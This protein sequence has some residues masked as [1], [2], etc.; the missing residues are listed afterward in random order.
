MGDAAA[1]GYASGRTGEPVYDEIVTGT[2]SLRAHWQPLLAQ[3]SPLNSKDMA[4]RVE[5]SMRLL[6]ENDVTYTVYGDPQNIAQ[7]NERLWPLDIMP[8][9]ISAEE[10]R[11]I[12][13]G[14]LQRARLLNT[15]LG[16]IY[17]ARRCVADGVLP[18]M[19]LEGNPA[20][21]RPCHD[22][23]PIGGTYLHLYAADLGR[24]ANGQWCVLA[25]RTETPSG[26]GYALENRS[27]IGR[28]LADCMDPTV[29]GTR[30]APLTPFFNTFRD[31]LLALAPPNR[32]TREAPRIVLLT[33]GPYNETYFEHLY[34][35]GHLGVTLVQG[36]DLTVRDRRVYIKTVSA[37]ETVDIILRRVDD[38]FCDPLELYRDSALGVAGLLEAVRAGTVTVANALG[39]GAVQAAAFKPFFPALSRALIGEDLVLPDA[40][41]WW[42]GG[43]AEKNH[44]LGSLDDLAVRPA[45]APLS[46][47]RAAQTDLSQADR[48]N[49]TARIAARPQDYVGQTRVTLSSAPVW[50]GGKMEPRP[51][52]LRVY[53][54]MGPDG[55]VVMPGGLTRTSRPGGVHAISMQS[56]GGS[57]DTWVLQSKMDDIAARASETSSNIVA[58]PEIAVRRTSPGALPSR[59]ADSLFWTGRYAERTNSTVRLLRTIVAGLT[60]P[61]RGWDLHD[62]E[63]LLNLSAYT[64][65]LPWIDPESA[66]PQQIIALVHRALFEPSQAGGIRAQLNKL[67]GAAG[68]V[69]DRLPADCW[70]ALTALGRAPLVSMS[71]ATPVQ[72][73]LRLNEL[74]TLGTSLAGAIDESMPRGDSWHFLE[75]GKRLERAIQLVALM[76]GISGVRFSG[77]AITHVSERRQLQA[78]VALVG[79]NVEPGSARLPDRRAVLEAVLANGDDPRTLVYQLISLNTHL[80][81]LPHSVT[82]DGAAA[83]LV[84]Q[85]AERVA[86]ALV[87]VRDAI[88]AATRGGKK[89]S[90]APHP[91]NNSLRAAFSLLDA[92]LPEIS[93]LLSRAYFTHAFAR[94]A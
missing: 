12:S 43:E 82:R 78:I 29:G 91:E 7:S 42:C 83:G 53:V 71:R 89:P 5:E 1:F 31:G 24:A 63:P 67:I 17:G 45:F 72:V 44:V 85:A 62:A 75:I 38:K 27:V 80:A 55:F 46:I 36:A 56:G 14:A 66:T 93:D 48:E 64:G 74:V 23:K 86:G 19:L 94:R 51:V 57:K 61:A 58:L 39:A 2:G 18:P 84:T 68:D 22:L 6:R 87:M 41:S 34:L 28:V 73:L 76:R 60:D 16:D 9:L 52:S 11:S 79:A 13:A 70:H 65:L 54:A 59:V 37:L 40:P 77:E 20:F 50:E 33:P 21:L 10:W 26:A 30:I 47:L 32:V 8:L 92:V 15:V 90:D 88:A 4:E 69:R 49:L 35:A 81:L 25:D 3:L